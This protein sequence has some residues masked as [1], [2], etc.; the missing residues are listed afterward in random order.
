MIQSTGN[1]PETAQL[2]LKLD[3]GRDG[4]DTRRV[5]KRAN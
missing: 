2:S 5:F 1:S 3:L 4:T